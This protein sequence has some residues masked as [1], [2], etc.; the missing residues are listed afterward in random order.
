[1]AVLKI[2][3][4]NGTVTEIVTIKGDT[5]PKGDK[6][7]PGDSSAP[8]A[9][10]HAAGG[11]DPITPQSIGAALEEHTHPQADWNQNDS[12]APD[13]VKN[14]PFYSGGFEIT[15]D[16]D[17]TGKVS[18]DVSSYTYYKV[19][20]MTPSSDELIG[21]TVTYNDGYTETLIQ[22][23]ITS[24]DGALFSDF[25]CVCVQ[26]GTYYGTTFTEAGTYFID[27]G[28]GEYV[29]S[30]SFGSVVP[31]PE[32]YIPDTVIRTSDIAQE[33]SSSD[34]STVIPSSPA[35]QAY[36][37]N[38]VANNVDVP[39]EYITWWATL[40]A[41]EWILADTH[42]RTGYVLQNIVPRDIYGN[43][44][45]DVS[46][47]YGVDV[48]CSPLINEDTDYTHEWCVCGVQLYD[49]D[50]HN[51]LQFYSAKKPTADLECTMLVFGWVE[52]TG[53]GAI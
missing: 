13:Y 23:W 27:Y 30:L 6:G 35:V 8:H 3:D 40:P 44:V 45:S 4:N 28:D 39:S 42:G 26:P 22:D 18:A 48:I 47:R 15:W 20:D 11:S 31:I 53:G 10:R 5:G 17:T 50:S 24:L 1:M 38:Y 51:K 2:R 7:D 16:G 25:G 34:A 46:G 9:S 49:A 12:T 14:R 32:Q 36:V 37:E 33:I 52:H 19:S 43:P 21:A 41:S 29:S